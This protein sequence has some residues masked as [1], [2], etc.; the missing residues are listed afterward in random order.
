MEETNKTGEMPVYKLKTQLYSM[1]IHRLFY[2]FFIIIIIVICLAGIF[3]KWSDNFTTYIPTSGGTYTVASTNSIRYIDPIFANNDTEKA[4]SQI[5]YA[6]IKAHRGEDYINDL[7]DKIDISSDGLIYTIQ[8]KSVKFSDGIDLTANDVVYTIELIQD[9][10]IESPKHKDWRNI[11]AS[12]IDM[13]TVELKLKT[14]SAAKHIDQTLTQGIIKKSEWVTLPKGSLSLSNLNINAIGSGPYKLDSSEENNKIISQI[15]LKINTN[16]KNISTLPYIAN[17]DYKIYADNN[18]IYNSIKN[19]EDLTAIN[20][21]TNIAAELTK[22]NKNITIQKSKMYRTFGLFFNPNNDK[23][24]ISIDFRSDLSSSINKKQIIYNILSGYADTGY[25]IYNKDYNNGHVEGDSVITSNGV[26]DNKYKGRNISLY[27]V[28]NT[29]LIKIAN[30]I[31]NDWARIGVN[32]EIKSYES[33][34][35]KQDIIKN[36]NFSILL[37]AVD[38]YDADDIYNLW[39]SSGRSYPGTNITNYYSNSLDKSLES[40]VKMEEEYST[41]DRNNLNSQKALIY[42]NINDELVNS[43]A[44]I[45]LYTPYTLYTQSNAVNMTT[46]SHMLYKNEYIDNINS[47]FI[48][49]EKVYNIFSNFSFNKTLSDFIQK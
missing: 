11:S 39:H 16:Y 7:A 23:D 47:A 14:L 6:G 25:Y 24:L 3:I 8:L 46:P 45:P 41:A 49:T 44:W 5:I 21:D 12:V 22:D 20:I 42:K 18:Q 37:F 32:V 17:I 36:R 35:L 33:G 2:L 48:N 13:H 27:T 31:K 9:S 38:T 4:V 10:L 29:D 1:P 43:V 15:H 34:E 40:L 26:V 30:S 19:G 28:N